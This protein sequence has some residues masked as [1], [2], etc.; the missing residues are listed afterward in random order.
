MSQPV[1]CTEVVLECFRQ[2]VQ[3]CR[4]SLF[5]K[6]YLR[7]RVRFHTELPEHW[8][9]RF[10]KLLWCTHVQSLPLEGWLCMSKRP[11]CVCIVSLETSTSQFCMHVSCFFISKQ[12]LINL[13]CRNQDG[14]RI[15]QCFKKKRL[16]LSTIILGRDEVVRKS[17]FGDTNSLLGNCVPSTWIRTPT[18][19]KPLAALCAHLSL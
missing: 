16:T 10:D 8:L 19:W 17:G 1:G 9:P 6:N 13:C 7:R 14:C 5:H 3:S 12:S 2:Y 4:S 18:I 15:T 11:R